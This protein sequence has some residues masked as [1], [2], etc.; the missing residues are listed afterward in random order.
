MEDETSPDE[1][2]ASHNQKAKVGQDHYDL[3]WE[4]EEVVEEDG[5]L[6]EVGPRS[7]LRILEVALVA[8]RCHTD[9]ND[10]PVEDTKG[11]K[12]MMMMTTTRRPDT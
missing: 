5:I 11:T 4:Q 2:Q 6:E 1:V 8:D 3:L 12:N 9:G 7:Y 10:D